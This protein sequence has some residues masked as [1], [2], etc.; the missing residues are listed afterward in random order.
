MTKRRYD[1]HIHTEQLS[2]QAAELVVVE[3]HNALE[4]VGF[5]YLSS[6]LASEHAFPLDPSALPLDERGFEFRGGAILGVVDDYL[7]DDWGRRILSQIAFYQHHKKYNPNSIID[8][9]DMLTRSR[10]GGLSIVSQGEQPQFDFGANIAQ[11]GI[12]ESAAQ[13]MDAPEARDSYDEASLLYLADNGTGIGGA[14]P[15]ALLHDAEKRYIAKFNRPAVDRYNNARVE[16]ACMKMARKANI[17]I[18]DGFVQSGINERE[19]LLVERFDVNPDKSRNHMISINTLLRDSESQR[20]AHHAFR[21]DDIYHMLQQFSVAIE[22][23]VMALLRLMLFNRAINNTDDHERNFS[24]IYRMGDSQ[25]HGYRLA[26]AYDLV[27]TTIRGGYH[28]AGYKQ[29]P[30]PPS[31]SELESAQRIFGLSRSIVSQCVAEVGDAISQWG[32]IAKACGVD[33]EE[34]KMVRGFFNH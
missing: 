3:A 23:D 14:R 33:P 1:L 17:E 25:P 8:S 2:M 24:L 13:R 12:A 34:A 15:K 31:L 7:P 16:L 21:Y 11:T 4:A 29:S 28:A 9:L 32:E 6:Y 22:E 27:P 26:P 5:R 18:L 20:M 10:I 19:V 30:N